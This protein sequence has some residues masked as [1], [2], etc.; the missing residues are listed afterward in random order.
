MSKRRSK[1]VLP[2]LGIDA[3]EIPDIV[4][5]WVEIYVDGLRMAKVKRAPNRRQLTIAFQARPG[6]QRIDVDAVR[7]VWFRKK[8]IPLKEWITTRKG[9]TEEES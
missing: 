7:G 1:V 2:S 3:R 6:V 9:K 5:R 4:G 8:M